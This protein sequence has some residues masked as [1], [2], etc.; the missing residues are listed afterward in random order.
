MSSRT[1]IEIRGLSKRFGTVEAVSDLTFTV[2]PGTVTGF[3]G[4]NGAGKTT[5][6]RMLLGLVRPNEGTATIGGA[7]YRDL[8]SPL[9][10]VGTALE[11]ASFHPGRTARNHLAVYTAAAGLPSARVG[12]VLD[13]V[14]LGAYGDRRVGGYSLG[15]RQRLGLAMALLGDP[16]VLVLDEPVNGLD[17]EGIRWIRTFLRELAAEGRTVLVSSHLLSEV[18]QSVDRLV[19]ISRGKLVYEGG[20]AGLDTDTRV[21]ADSPHR[22]MLDAALLAAGAEIQSSD[23]GVIVSSLTAVEVGAIAHRAGVPLSLLHT[24]QGGLE[25]AFL[26]LVGEGGKL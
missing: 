2:E 14:G 1:T 23:A 6:L 26:E 10:T 9:T 16:Q 12:T 4:P 24:Q 5:T 8:T 15:M 22:G 25:Q 13:L 17:P 19:V 18:Q 11:A 20:L 21:I 7:S 3:L